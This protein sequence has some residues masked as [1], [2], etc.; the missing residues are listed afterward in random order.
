M[1]KAAKILCPSADVENEKSLTQAHFIFYS[2]LSKIT[3]DFTIQW[4][5][6]FELLFYYSFQN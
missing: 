6:Q 5:N 2:K 4:T 3:L 1:G